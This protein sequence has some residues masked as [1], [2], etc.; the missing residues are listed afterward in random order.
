MPG[1]CA[2]ASPGSPTGPTSGCTGSSPAAA[3]EPIT[4]EPA[5]PRADRYADGDVAAGRRHDRLRARAARRPAATDVRNEV[6]RLDAHAPSK[7]EVLVSGPDFVAAPRLYPGRRHAGLAAV[8][9]PVDAVGR[10]GAGGARPG[11]RRGD[12]GGRRAAASRCPEPRCAPRR[13]AAGS[14]PTAPE[15]WNLYRWTPGHRHRAGRARRRGDRRARAGCSGRPATRVLRRRAGGVRTVRRNG[16]DT[17]RGA[18]ADGTLVDLDVA[19]LG[20]RRGARPPGRTRSWWWPAAPTSR[21]RGAP[22]RRRPPSAAEP[23]L[24]R[25]GSCGLDPGQL[26]V[27]EPITFDSVDRATGA[28]RTAHALFYPPAN[29]GPPGPDG[30]RAAAAGDDPRRPDRR[31]RCRC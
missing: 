12:G 21:A 13:V 4:P 30:E 10:H 20:D 27:P 5:A 26:S 25:R 11:H 2:T 6:V 23:L 29:A 28:P 1:G 19:V 7:P 14:C 15:W 3:P 17:P 22:G 31:P 9:P 16:C 18:A 24:A 8:E